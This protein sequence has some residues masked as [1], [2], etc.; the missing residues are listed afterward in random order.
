MVG[1]Y[2]N[3]PLDW[4]VS[5]TVQRGGDHGIGQ[6]V[7]VGVVGRDLAVENEVLAGARGLIRGDRRGVGDRLRLEGTD[8]DGAAAGPGQT[9]A[10]R[11]SRR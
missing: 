7:V 1:V 10:G 2:V 5:A 4:S 8:I 11:W 3:E 6:G 9:R